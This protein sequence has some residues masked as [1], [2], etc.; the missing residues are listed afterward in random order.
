MSRLRDIAQASASPK[1]L[2]QRGLMV[3][4]VLT[5]VTLLV[6]GR[7]NHPFL[8]SARIHTLQM[9]SPVLE[10][11]RSPVESF[12]EFRTYLGEVSATYSQNLALREENEGLRRWQSVAVALQAENQALRELMQY[13]PVARSRYITAKVIAD[14]Q[15]AGAHSLLLNAGEA[16]GVQ[17]YQPVVDA[18][19]LIG[20]VLEVSRSNA[21]VLT[22]SDA[23]SRIP[24]TT[25][26]TRTRAILSGTGG[27]TLRLTFMAPGAM[28]K[29]GEAILTTDDGAL[30]P[31]GVMVGTVV[32][33]SDDEV[34]VKPVRPLGA[35]DYVRVIHYETT[36]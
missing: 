17:R 34:L 24:V 14:L 33:V 22:L 26:E 5:G 16:Q 7:A 30:M 25:G 32:R 13:Q 15:G 3:V 8:A 11:V 28:P 2:I 20:R 6:L 27:D 29:A 31:A 10:V 35:P 18:H 12:R 36:P 23:N 9:L 21:R 19:G 4:C 1:L